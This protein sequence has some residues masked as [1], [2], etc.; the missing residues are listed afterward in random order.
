MIAA[1]P[2]YGGG[3]AQGPPDKANLAGISGAVLAESKVFAEFN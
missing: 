3:G 2:A 1:L